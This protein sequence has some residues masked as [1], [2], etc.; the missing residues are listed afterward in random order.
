[1]KNFSYFIKEAFSSLSSNK[2]VTFMTLI[3][4]VISLI[5]T[6]FIQLV[7]VNL[8]HI[9]NQLS[10]NFEFN[11]YIKDSVADEELES[12]RQDILQVAMV[13]DAVLMTKSE[14]FQEFKSKMSDDPLL[15]GLSEEDNPFRN[16]FMVTVTDLN[17]ADRVMDEIRMI[18][19]V[20]AISDNLE[21]SQK[22]VDAR[23]KINLYSIIIYL[24]LALLCLSI[25]SNIINVSIFSR[26]KHINIMK[27]V[28]ATNWFVKTP[29]VIEGV[30]VGLFGAIFSTVLL[31]YGYHLIYPKIY[32]VMQGVFLIQPMAIFYQL[33]GINTVYGVCIGGLGAGFA[34]N[35]YLKV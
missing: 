14:A 12:V 23:E 22:L 4:I 1:M 16:R 34:V 35:K 17:Q 21:T 29:F 25:I 32:M 6:G 30:L 24:A 31:A 5:V 10:S 18:S 19:E 11:I 15:K 27:Y 9:S 13:D 33:L 26:R 8:V 7:S 20:D 2:T 3:T 28:G